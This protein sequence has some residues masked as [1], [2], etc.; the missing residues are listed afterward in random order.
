MKIA[1]IG[2]GPA[3]YTAA[4]R[5]AQLGAEVYLYEKKLLGGACLNWACIPTKYMLNSLTSQT[6]HDSIN[7][8][9]AFIDSR[10]EGLKTL[11]EN[12]GI[13]IVMGE[14]RL[15]G[16]KSVS[17]SSASRSGAWSWHYWPSYR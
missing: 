12:H 5:C 3:G 7:N 14:A 6:W 2:S 15:D 17:S 9:N 4:I 10:R 11:L 16:Q 1:V 13:K 8:K